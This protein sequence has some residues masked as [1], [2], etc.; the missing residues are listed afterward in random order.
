MEAT[1]NQSSINQSNE[2]AKTIGWAFKVDSKFDNFFLSLLFYKLI[3]NQDH[4][5]FNFFTNIKAPLLP[6]KILLPIHDKGSLLVTMWSIINYLKDISIA[7]ISEIWYF[8]DLLCSPTSPHN[9]PILSSNSAINAD[10]EY[11]NQ[12]LI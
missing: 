2:L 9:H 8:T 7:M 4:C 3:P 11:V 1:I 12:N 5:N 6:L 10:I